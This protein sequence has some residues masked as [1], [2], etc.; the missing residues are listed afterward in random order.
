MKLEPPPNPRAEGIR[1]L[2]HYMPL[3]S[4]DAEAKADRK[5][6]HRIDLK[7]ALK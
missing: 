7:D 6:L 4:D 3:P 2:R 5:L 1:S